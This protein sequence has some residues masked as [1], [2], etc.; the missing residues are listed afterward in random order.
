MYVMCRTYLAIMCLEVSVALVPCRLA[1]EESLSGVRCALFGEELD[2]CAC[3]RKS[4]LYILAS[5][6]L[7]WSSTTIPIEVLLIFDEDL[8]G[9]F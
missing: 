1:C 8:L 2:G 5:T 3:E 6:G 4:S 9:L 7:T